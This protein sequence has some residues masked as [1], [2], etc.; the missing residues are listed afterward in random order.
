MTNV[1][2]GLRRS[3][4]QVPMREVEIINERPLNQSVA[5]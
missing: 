4:S 2:A 1:G 3:V 5:Y